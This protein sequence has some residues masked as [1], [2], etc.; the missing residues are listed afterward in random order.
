MTACVAIVGAGL[1]GSGL[2]ER[3]ARAGLDVVLHDVSPAALARAHAGLRPPS[4][5]A[6]VRC[7]SALGDLSGADLVI[8][9]VPEQLPL[10]RGL[11]SSLER[12]AP[13]AVLS[14]NSS[15]F[16]PQELGT[17]LAAPGRFLN[18]HFLGPETGNPLA[19]L[20]RGPATDDVAAAR[21]E[22]L[23]TE[24]GFRP[25]RVGACRAFV[26]NRLGNAGVGNLGRAVDLGLL[27]EACFPRYHVVMRPRPRP[28][29]VLDHIGLDVLVAVLRACHE[30]YGPRFGVPA[31]L[32]RAV[33]EGRLGVKT[34][35]GL[36]D[37]A[38][39]P[40]GRAALDARPLPLEARPRTPVRTIAVRRPG[41][42]SSNLLSALLG[43]EGRQLLLVRAEAEPFLERA[44]ARA[45]RFFDQLAGR[46]R[47][48][49][50]PDAQ[51]ADLLLDCAWDEGLEE[52]ARGLGPWRANADV[53]LL[54]SS[55]HLQAAALA[56]ALRP[57]RGLGVVFG[58]RGQ[59][60]DVELVRARQP[61][62]HR[63]FRDLLLEAVG[64]VLDV[65]DGAVRPLALLI[66]PRL[67]EAQRIVAEGVAT[68]AQVAELWGEDPLRDWDEWR[69]AA[70]DRTCAAAESVLGVSLR[71][72]LAWEGA[73]A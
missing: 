42:L 23:L 62:A 41:L 39:D 22:Q 72:G 18:L 24:A 34:G 27:P 1:Q 37:H 20:I 67:L 58:V 68:I 7:T 3:F 2:A 40:T 9:A 32:T 56:D 49:D 38:A 50:A 5:R 33:A 52:K 4:A 28:A 21:A 35:R 16:T 66:V 65:S 48:L 69:G 57:T 61:D 36:I 25:V 13:A 31:W 10:K 53:P 30:S 44:R 54:V 55:P 12:I 15:S 63:L 26:Y 17:E 64:R 46:L 47:L 59:A 60:L 45:P 70:L 51:G 8:E 11:L 43:P 6:R 73:V 19:E 29:A 14:S 71:D